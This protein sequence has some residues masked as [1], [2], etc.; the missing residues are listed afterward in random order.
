M[1][2]ATPDIAL[3]LASAR[4]PS[5]PTP[6]HDPEAL[7][8]KCHEFE[9]ILV[10]SM[11]KGM[12]STVPEGGLL[13]KGMGREIFEELRDVE[14]ARKLSRHQGLGLGEALFRQLQGL[15]NVR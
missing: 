15:E 5:V 10:Q 7:R 6:R 1:I 14:I 4:T 13:D 3:S 12:R 8:E 11:F 9:A 2:S